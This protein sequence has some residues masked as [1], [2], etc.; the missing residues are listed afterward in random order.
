MNCT[1]MDNPCL[2]IQYA[3]DSVAIPN[4]IIKIDGGLGNFVLPGS[5]R[6]SN[7]INITF[8]SY[9]GVAWVYR[10]SLSYRSTP[11]LATYLL[12]KVVKC[13]LH[14]NTLNTSFR[15]IA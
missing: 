14:F 2:T 15:E 1:T 6:L 12:K 9:N 5:V 10:S 3:I 4:D 7:C 13:E 8:T 11:F